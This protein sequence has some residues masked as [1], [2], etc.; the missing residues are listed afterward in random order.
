MPRA[1][2]PHLTAQKAQTKEED[3]DRNRSRG[4]SCS[5]YAY[6]HWDLG[7]ALESIARVGYAGVEI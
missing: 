3:H 1:P 2:R 4:I 7:Q 6:G 5:T